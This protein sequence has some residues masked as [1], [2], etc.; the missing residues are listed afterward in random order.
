MFETM[1][2][3]PGIGLAATQVDVI[4]HSM[5]GLVAR[6]CLRRHGGAKQCFR[7]CL[8][9]LWRHKRLYHL[10]DDHH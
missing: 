5:G 10:H 4:G 2:E 9:Y 7:L 6:A 3:G 1:Y 8:G